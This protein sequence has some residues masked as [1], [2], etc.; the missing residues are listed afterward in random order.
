MNSEIFLSLGSNLGNKSLHLE[1]A[2]TDIVLSIGPV[3][4]ASMVYK[5][6][7]WGY[8]HQPEFYNQVLQ[9][10]SSLSPEEV[11]EKIQYIEKNLGRVRK[12]KWG[13]RTI[14]ID[15]L[16]YGQ[17]VVY[18]DKLIIPH[19]LLKDRRFVL[20]PLAEIAPA[21]IHPVEHRSVLELLAQCNDP[22]AVTK[23]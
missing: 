19:P 9:V 15:I 13:E 14:D 5:T 7:A 8:Q 4:Q 17:E 20:Q 1:Q 16:F 21:F 23:L 18:N 2:T 11:L 3:L 22:L 6:A 10:Q 12:E